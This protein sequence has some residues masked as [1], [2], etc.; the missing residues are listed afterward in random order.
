MNQTWGPILFGLAVVGFGLFV[1]L[2]AGQPTTDNVVTDITVHDN[3][4]ADWT[5][6]FRTN[7]QT[8]D[9][10]AAYERFQVEFR[11]NSSTHLASFESRMGNVVSAVDTETDREMRAYS[12][13][14]ETEIEGY[15][16]QRG[17][18]RYTFTWEN[19]AKPEDDT[20]HIGDAF[21]GGHFLADGE[22]LSIYAPDGYTITSVNP[23]PN[24]QVMD[25]PKM[26]RWNGERDFT[27][28]EPTVIM[29]P[30]SATS[31]GEG[32]TDNDDNGSTTDAEPSTLVM[33]GVLLVLIAAISLS[34]LWRR[35]RPQTS[36]TP[37]TAT[38]TADTNSD[39]TTDREQVLAL[40]SDGDRVKQTHIR[41]ELGWSDS[42]TSRV[43]SEMADDDDIEKLRIGR[44]NVV[45]SADDEAKDR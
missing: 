13:D 21:D 5:V 42:K 4:S 15:A 33:A 25:P 22:R 7:L 9:D 8:D 37:T 11:E 17:V 41:D 20:L 24:T 26:V 3:G 6:E 29:S 10:I 45:R 39:L 36:T 23:T 44:E 14:V 1:G 18:V 2:S 34:V 27:A 19:F 31:P 16:T 12:F 28:G 32:N 40:L 30:E 35:R 38:P 43:L